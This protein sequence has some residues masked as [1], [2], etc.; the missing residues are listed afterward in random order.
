MNNQQNSQK[1]INSGKQKIG[2]VDHLLPK[3]TN[4]EIDLEIDMNRD[5]EITAEKPPHHS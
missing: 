3:L 1:N 4:D 5:A 2:E